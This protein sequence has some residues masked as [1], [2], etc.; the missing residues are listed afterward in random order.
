MP[1]GNKM[2]YANKSTMKGAKTRPDPGQAQN[3]GRSQPQFTRGG[4]GGPQER[5]GRARRGLRGSQNFTNLN[6]RGDNVSKSGR[7][8]RILKS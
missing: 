5:R 6:L 8:K 4:M 3:M 1:H 2:K 7:M